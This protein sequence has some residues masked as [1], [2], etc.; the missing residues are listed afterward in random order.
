MGRW[1][2]KTE[3]NLSG[4]FVT[5][6]DDSPGVAVTVTTDRDGR[7]HIQNLD[8]AMYQIR[9]HQS[10]YED[11]TLAQAVDSD[12]TGLKLVMQSAEGTPDVLPASTI[13][14]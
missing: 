14:R 4:I 13:A 10:R 9:I 7:F 1:A 8:T 12:V 11:V 3:S 6:R 2:R 5:V